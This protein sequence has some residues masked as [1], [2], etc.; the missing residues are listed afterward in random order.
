MTVGGGID[1]SHLLTRGREDPEQQKNAYVIN[2]WP[3]RGNPK[4][5]FEDEMRML[6]K[7]NKE[8]LLGFNWSSS[9]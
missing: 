5:T 6:E 3:L 7:Y 1:I 9:Q 4:L 8:E 2:E